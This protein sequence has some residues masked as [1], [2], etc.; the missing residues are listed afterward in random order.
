M[1]LEQE[2]ETFDR[3]LD[4]QLP[5]IDDLERLHE[6]VGRGLI[7][8]KG[9]LTGREIEFLR[10][11]MSMS[12][13]WLAHLLGVSR[14]MIS[15]WEKGTTPTPAETDQSIRF[16]YLAHV[17]GGA[18]ALRGGSPAHEIGDRAGVH[19][20]AGATR[21]GDEEREGCEGEVRRNAARANAGCLTMTSGGTPLRAKPSQARG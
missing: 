2:P 14:Q 3:K 9:L 12:Q 13:G 8:K 20:V 7:K 21:V 5:G 11:H 16:F 17:H 19:Q 15:R 4:E 1:S 10:I 18:G 6:A